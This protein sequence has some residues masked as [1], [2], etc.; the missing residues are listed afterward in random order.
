LAVPVPVACGPPHENHPEY[1]KWLEDLRA[2]DREYEALPLTLE[3]G[4]AG[5]EA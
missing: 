4:G 2:H 1:E 5:R 3:P